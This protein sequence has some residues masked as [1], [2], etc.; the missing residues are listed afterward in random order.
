MEQSLALQ[1]LEPLGK[2]QTGL[3]PVSALLSQYCLAIAALGVL[4]PGQR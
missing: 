1:K 3:N 2:I 4:R